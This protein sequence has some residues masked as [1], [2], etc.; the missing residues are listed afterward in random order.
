MPCSRPHALCAPRRPRRITAVQ[1]VA[2][3]ER[4]RI[5]LALRMS[6][7]WFS[8]AE[9]HPDPPAHAQLCRRRSVSR[10]PRPRTA[11][12]AAIRPPRRSAHAVGD[13]AS[14]PWCALSRARR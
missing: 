4:G 13:A 9:R 8:A 14:T 11:S 7:H 3:P 12:S 6:S 10:R 5:G 1:V 2:M